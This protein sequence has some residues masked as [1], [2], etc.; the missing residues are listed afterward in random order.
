[1][2][3]QAAQC[4]AGSAFN[5]TEVRIARLLDDLRAHLEV[6]EDLHESMRRAVD[7]SAEEASKSGLQPAPKEVLDALHVSCFDAA[8]LKSL[9]QTAQCVICCA[10]W[11]PG[12]ELARLPGCGHLFHP[13]CVRE[14]LGHA[15]NCPICR[16]DLVEAV[17]AP[18]DEPSQASSPSAAIQT[19]MPPV[20]AANDENQALERPA[21]AA[22]SAVAPV[23]AL[24]ASPLSSRHGGWSS[25]DS[26]AAH[27]LTTSPASSSAPAASSS[28]SSSSRAMGSASM[29]PAGRHVLEARASPSNAIQGVPGLSRRSTGTGTTAPRHAPASSVLRGAGSSTLP[30][31]APGSPGQ[32]RSP[33]G[34]SGAN[35]QLHSTAIPST[36]GVRRPS[37]ESAGQDIH[38]VVRLAAANR[39]SRNW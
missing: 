4:L 2:V 14:W 5:S 30:T 9:R 21:A 23:T 17:N 22:L 11:E 29:S 28:S 27:S 8:A 24:P 20:L 3:M 31:A 35:H 13:V 16:C 25:P 12:E 36:T 34:R 18:H 1:M 26:S 6:V 33:A 15:A 39:L 19:V 7:R 37:A 10:D 32:P 38:S